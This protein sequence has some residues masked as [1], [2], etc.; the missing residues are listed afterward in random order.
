MT[1]FLC[2]RHGKCA[3]IGKYIAGR[4]SGIH[5][6]KEGQD[7]V[8]QLSDNLKTIGISKVYSS[9]LERAQETA[10]IICRKRNLDYEIRQELNEIDYGEWSGRTF[11]ELSQIPLW[12]DFNRAKGLIRIPQ[13]EL[14]IEIESRVAVFVENIR[15]NS[16]GIVALVSHAEPIKCLIAHYAGIPLDLVGRVEIDTASVSVL[17][18]NGF[19]ANIICVNHTGD[20][21]KV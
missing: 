10:E 2:I 19:C 8:A 1:V 13:G 17:K 18:L 14:L 3:P 12:H 20:I 21:I 4:I 15:K 5:L 6:N 9:P 7:E 11:D 16:D